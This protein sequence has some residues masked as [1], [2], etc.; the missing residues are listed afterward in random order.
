MPSARNGSASPTRPA[1][2][3]SST[4]EG[5]MLLKL[6]RSAAFCA[7]CMLNRAATSLPTPS[8]V[9]KLPN[10]AMA[11]SAAFWLMPSD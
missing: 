8:V 6:A 5:S 9:N 7:S 10:V 11:D 3:F 2:S 4:I 1:C